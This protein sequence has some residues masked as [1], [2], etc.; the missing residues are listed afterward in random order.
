MNGQG[1]KPA[2]SRLG[3]RSGLAPDFVLFASFRKERGEG[4]PRSSFWGLVCSFAL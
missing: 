4:W 2:A 3:V 1:A